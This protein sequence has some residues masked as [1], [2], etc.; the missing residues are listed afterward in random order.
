MIITGTILLL[1]SYLLGSIPTSVWIGKVF[2][3]VDVR[4]HGSGN[5]GATN[6]FRTLGKTAGIP[7][8]IFDSMKG[9]LAVMMPVWFLSAGDSPVLFENFRVLCGT[10][11]VIGHV[12]PVFAGFR[13]GKGVATLL[14]VAAGM[15][16]VAALICIGLFLLVLL[17]T[18]YVSLG[19]ILASLFYGIFLL[20]I[21]KVH[22]DAT[23]IF[24]IMIP[25]L[26]II[27]HSKNIRRLLDGNESRT[28]LNPRKRN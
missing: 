24:A 14:G 23:I 25:V 1:I 4:E 5:A 2:Y 8:L 9:W 13:G 16:P 26:V 22:H 11:A 10:A 15:Q 28:Y 21:D 27:T 12:F 18:H 20:A 7:V 17:L 3:G 6:T 19:S